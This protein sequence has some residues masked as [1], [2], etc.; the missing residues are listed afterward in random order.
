MS[1]RLECSVNS[2]CVTVSY[3]QGD[4]RM[5]FVFSRVEYCDMHFMCGFWKGNSHAAVEEFQRRISDRRFPSRG[6]FTRINQTLCDP[7][8]FT[9][10]VVRSEWS[11]DERLTHERT[12][13]R[14]F[15]EVHVYPILE[16]PL[17]SA[18]HVCSCGELYIK[19]IYI[20]TMIKGYNIRKQATINNV[21]ISA[22]W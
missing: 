14:W 16:W 6:V 9:S 15:R 5:A 18:Y 22:A 13:L 8:F 7:G 3:L 11:W 17:A 21:W 19:K 1:L 2:A 12:F 20:L 10:V 4:G